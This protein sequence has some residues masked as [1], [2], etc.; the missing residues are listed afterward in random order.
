MVI[1]PLPAAAAGS[2]SVTY[3]N[4]PAQCV[5]EESLLDTDETPNKY[6]FVPAELVTGGIA[7]MSC[8]VAQSPF[9][10][11]SPSSQTGSPEGSPFIA[12]RS[13][14]RLPGWC[15]SHRCHTRGPPQS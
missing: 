15:S 4:M 12:S 9:R 13:S 2:I 1:T 11:T 14:Q 8:L 3:T 7:G 10:K 5:A 6:L